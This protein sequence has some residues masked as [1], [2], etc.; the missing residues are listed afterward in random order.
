MVFFGLFAIPPKT[1][2]PMPTL[3]ENKIKWLTQKSYCV[4]IHTIGDGLRA[5]THRLDKQG[6]AGKG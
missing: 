1:R 3:S 6:K 4:R 2:Q 5:E